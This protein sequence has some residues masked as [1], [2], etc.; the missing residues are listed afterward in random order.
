MQVEIN[1][2]LL[3]NY[4]ELF[5][6]YISNR[7]NSVNER[8]WEQAKQMKAHRRTMIVHINLQQT[9]IVHTLNKLQQKLFL[10]VIS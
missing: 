6:D 1:I 9:M 5:L 7:G 8:D 2:A 3:L 4:P 10:N